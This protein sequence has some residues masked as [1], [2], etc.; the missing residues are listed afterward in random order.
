MET[1]CQW[2]NSDTLRIE[3]ILTETSTGRV[4]AEGFREKADPMAYNVKGRSYPICNHGVDV[5]HITLEKKLL[6]QSRVGFFLDS[7][8]LFIINLMSP[9]WQYELV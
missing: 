1:L 5:P 2:Y 3:Y 4:R 7:Y 6:I 9:I 8:D